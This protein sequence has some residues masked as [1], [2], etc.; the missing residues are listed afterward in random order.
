[1]AASKCLYELLIKTR[2]IGEETKIDRSYVSKGKQ[3]IRQFQEQ[4]K[5]ILISFHHKI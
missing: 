1:M 2:E 3:N 5:Q 4:N